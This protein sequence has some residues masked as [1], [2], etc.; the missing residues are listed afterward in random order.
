[1]KFS[2]CNFALLSHCWLCERYNDGSQLLQTFFLYRC[3]YLHL[4]ALHNAP[5]SEQQLCIHLIT[6]LYNF[7]L[8]L[9]HVDY[10]HG[11]KSRHQCKL[12]RV[13]IKT[14][15]GTSRSKKQQPNAGRTGHNHFPLDGFIMQFRSVECQR[16]FVALGNLCYTNIHVIPTYNWRTQQT[17]YGSCGLLK[18]IQY[19][20]IQY[21]TIQ[22]N[23][24]QYRSLM[25]TDLALYSPD[26]A[27]NNH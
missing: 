11:R 20:T 2:Y 18:D 22:Y 24:I 8:A 3:T 19:N 14:I 15:L 9:S 27:E 21:N 4:L 12:Q 23:T 1:M 17:Y 25:H 26:S 6:V 13:Q 5:N 7:R 16:C 10:F